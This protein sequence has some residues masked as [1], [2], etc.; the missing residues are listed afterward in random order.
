MCQ[1]SAK[2]YRGAGTRRRPGLPDSPNPEPLGGETKAGFSMPGLFPTALLSRNSTRTGFKFKYVIRGFRPN[3]FFAFKHNVLQ[4][5]VG[6]IKPIV[7][8]ET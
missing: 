8:A 6:N 4:G 1:D 5:T 7:G 3:I 2:G